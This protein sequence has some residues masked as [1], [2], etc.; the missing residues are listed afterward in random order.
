VLQG[1]RGGAAAAFI[2][3]WAG[4]KICYSFKPGIV[5]FQNTLADF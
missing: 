4:G 5:L 3:A 1:Y 2:V